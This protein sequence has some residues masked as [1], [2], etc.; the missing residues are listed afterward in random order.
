MIDEQKKA[1][2]YA[3]EMMQE[4]TTGNKQRLVKAKDCAK[5]T[6]CCCC[7]KRK[8]DTR[9]PLPKNTA[10]SPVGRSA[11]RAPALGSVAE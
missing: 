7:V 5:R 11:P 10:V 2:E 9:G 6:C 1:K 3:R 4:M 8:R